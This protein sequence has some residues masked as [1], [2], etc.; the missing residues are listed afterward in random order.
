MSTLTLGS[1]VIYVESGVQDILDFYRAAFGFETQFYDPDFDFGELETGGPSIAISSHKAGEFMTGSQYPRS[2][3]TRPANV[4][5]ALLTPD[6]DAAYTKAVS[7]GATPIAAPKTMPWGQ[8][9]AYVL[10]IE[11]T[12]IGLLTP[13][14]T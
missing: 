7:A 5:I 10:S 6:V 1:M 12:L 13:P 3:S 9:V 4:E 11:G 2:D 8:T 14:T